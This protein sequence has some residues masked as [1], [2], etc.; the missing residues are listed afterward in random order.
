MMVRLRRAPARGLSRPSGR[1]SRDL[2]TPYPQPEEGKQ[3]EPACLSD[4]FDQALRNCRISEIEC[5]NGSV[6]PYCYEKTA[7]E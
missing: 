3:Q 2:L 4:G 1:H 7:S 6:Q 5:E